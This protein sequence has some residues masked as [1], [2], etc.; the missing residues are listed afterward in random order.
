MIKQIRDLTLA[1]HFLP[2]AMVTLWKAALWLLAIL[3]VGVS[4][5]A[6]TSVPNRTSGMTEDRLIELCSSVDFEHPAC[7]M[8]WEANQDGTTDW[9]FRYLDSRW[10][11][12]TRRARLIHLPNCMD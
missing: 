4:L 5:F 12:C 7:E 3:L 10:G 6:C 1:L 8:N 2:S 9:D 11:D